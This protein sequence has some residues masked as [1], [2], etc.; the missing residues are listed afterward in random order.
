MFYLSEDYTSIMN[1]IHMLYMTPQGHF[2]CG[3]DK[4]EVH[5]YSENCKKYYGAWCKIYLT[6]FIDYSCLM[7]I[8]LLC[9]CTVALFISQ[10]HLLTEV[11]PMLI[12]VPPLAHVLQITEP[13]IQM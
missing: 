3:K 8:I 5:I 13:Q 1:V 11:V 7:T 9:V 6:L 10:R 4:T 12:L 2:T